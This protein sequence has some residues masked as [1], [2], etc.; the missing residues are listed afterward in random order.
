VAV[1]ETAMT[2]TP[3]ELGLCFLAGISYLI[4]MLVTITYYELYYGD[5]IK[6]QKYL[7][8]LPINH[9]PWEIEE[10]E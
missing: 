7:D 2:L 1:L 8:D 4:G 10:P 9:Y 3:H 5:A 6:A